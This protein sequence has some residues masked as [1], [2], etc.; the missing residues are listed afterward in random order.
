MEEWKQQSSTS[1]KR[2]INKGQKAD[3]SFQVVTEEKE[4]RAFWHMWYAM[5][6]D[7]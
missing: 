7:K 1:G 3:L 2:M 4:W 6:Y 5:S